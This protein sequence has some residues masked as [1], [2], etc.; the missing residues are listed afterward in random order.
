MDFKV[1]S[2]NKD[3]FD[4]WVAAMKEPGKLPADP[5][6]SQVFQ[7]QCLTCHAVGDKGLQLYP[8]LTGVGGRE[9]VGGILI[10]TDDPKYKNEGSAYDNLKRW[11][12]NPQQ[13]KS[14]NSMPKINLTP[15]QIDGIAKYLSEYK[16]DVE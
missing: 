8:N 6:I 4:R 14:G 1:K 2:V 3:S 13:V 5:A 15:E 11:I 10:N 9:T 16:L 12:S 7:K